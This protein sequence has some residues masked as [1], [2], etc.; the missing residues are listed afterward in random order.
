MKKEISAAQESYIECIAEAESLHGHA[1]ISTLA[2]ELGITKPS[3][4]QMTAKLVKQ[5]IAKRHHK[6]ITLTESG[7][8]IATMLCGC[9]KLLY[10]FM[11]KQLEMDKTTADKEACYLEHIVSKEFI[12]GLRAFL[13]KDEK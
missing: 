12:Q 7:R 1:H 9:H 13:K 4:V 3:V 6:E 10:N 8:R 11:V 2:D 5:G